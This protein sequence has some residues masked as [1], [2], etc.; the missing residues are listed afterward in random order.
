[1]FIFLPIYDEYFSK[2]S[3]IYRPLL[4]GLNDENL[5]VEVWDFD[6]AETIGE[7]MTKFLDIKGVRGFRKLMKEIAVTASTGKHDN[8]LIGRCSIPLRVSKLCYFIESFQFYFE[9]LNKTVTVWKISTLKF[10]I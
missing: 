8:E 4:T 7:K 5:I 10:P 6:P 9:C 3:M 2:I 1:M